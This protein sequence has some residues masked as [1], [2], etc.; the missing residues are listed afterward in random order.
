MYNSDDMIPIESN[1][2]TIYKTFSVSTHALVKSF[3]SEPSTEVQLSTSL[4]ASI[5][6]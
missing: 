6:Q 1:F 3:K 5:R 2:M 4:F